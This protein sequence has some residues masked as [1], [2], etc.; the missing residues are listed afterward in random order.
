MLTQ[1]KLG[2]AI[3]NDEKNIETNYRS[4]ILALSSPLKFREYRYVGTS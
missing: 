2:F 4:Q 1:P 3:E